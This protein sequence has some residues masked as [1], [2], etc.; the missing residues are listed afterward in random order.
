MQYIHSKEYFDCYYDPISVS[1]HEDT[2]KTYKSLGKFW[3]DL[4]LS[5]KESLMENISDK[6]LNFFTVDHD[7]TSLHDNQG[8]KFTNYLGTTPYTQTFY[9]MFCYFR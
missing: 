2:N 4:A 5:E 8:N 1:D 7:K 9:N 3:S 6:G